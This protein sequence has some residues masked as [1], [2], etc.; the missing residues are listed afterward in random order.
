MMEIY[1][2]KSYVNVDLSVFSHDLIVHK[3]SELQFT[4]V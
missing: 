2:N 1:C 3:I 4:A